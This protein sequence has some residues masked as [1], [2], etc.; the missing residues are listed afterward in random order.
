[1][2]N[3][4]LNSVDL[5]RLSEVNEAVARAKIERAEHVAEMLNAAGSWVKR[6]VVLAFSSLTHSTGNASTRHAH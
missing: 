4:K 6:T 1:M 2:S 5:T 3:S